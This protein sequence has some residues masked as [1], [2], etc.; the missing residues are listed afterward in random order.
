MCEELCDIPVTRHCIVYCQAI[1]KAFRQVREI[2]L[3]NAEGKGAANVENMTKT[4][5]DL[6]LNKNKDLRHV[7]GLG[8]DHLSAAVITR[9]QTG[10]GA[11]LR[12]QAPLLSSSRLTVLHTALLM[13][14]GTVSVFK[15]YQQAINA[16]Y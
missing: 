14:V 15:E 10:V 9:N 4:V 13:Q 6:L 7:V 5:T 8:T 2:F 3:G 16:V 11:R 12:L 1:D